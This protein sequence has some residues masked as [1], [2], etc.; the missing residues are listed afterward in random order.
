MLASLKT[1][2]SCFFLSSLFYSFDI[3]IICWDGGHIVSAFCVMIFF[4]ECLTF[5]LSCFS[6]H[7]YFSSEIA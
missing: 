6:L 3:N 5:S 1:V 4:N 7:E 2:E